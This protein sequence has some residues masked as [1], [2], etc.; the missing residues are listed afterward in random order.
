MY[1]VIE[2]GGKQYRVA[3][4]NKLKI[5]KLAVEAGENITFDLV[6]LIAEGEKIAIG[7][8]NLKGATVSATVLAQ[9]RAKKIRIVKHRRRKHYHK[10]MGHR[11]SFTEVQIN[12][13]KQ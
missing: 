2:T 5:E 6:K 8:P 1:A 4:G 12:D 7:T 11:Q 13:I 3:P 9:G 10:E